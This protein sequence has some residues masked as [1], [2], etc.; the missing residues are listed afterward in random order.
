MYPSIPIPTHLPL[1]GELTVLTFYGFGL[2]W[3]A[4]RRVFGS[5][6]EGHGGFASRFSF[7]GWPVQRRKNFL[8]SEIERFVVSGCS[9]RCN[10]TSRALSIF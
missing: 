1:V 3:R 5:I 10:Y 9:C 6:P 8:R 2:Y 4:A 7:W